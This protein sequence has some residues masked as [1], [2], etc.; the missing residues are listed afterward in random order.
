M[1]STKRQPMEVRAVRVPAEL[2]RDVRRAAKI[3]KM[4]MSDLIRSAILKSVREI[5]ELAQ[6]IIKEG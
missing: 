1:K 6:S 3:S 2:W 4:S 5:L